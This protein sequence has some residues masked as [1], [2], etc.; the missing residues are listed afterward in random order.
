MLPTMRLASAAALLAALLPSTSFAQLHSDCNPLKGDKCPPNPAFGT[1]HEFN[2]NQS[3]PAGMFTNEAGMPVFNADTGGAFTISKQGQS[4]TYKTN[5]YFFWGRTEVIMKAAAGQ[6]IVSS[7]VLMSDVLDEIDWEFLGSKPNWVLTN[8]FGKGE[9]HWTNGGNS[10][11]P[12]SLQTQWHNFTNVWTKDKLEWWLD[13]D[14]VR[15]LTPKQANNTRNY[16]QTPM[17]LSLGIWSGG[18]P[19]LNPPGT[20]EWAGGET[21]FTKAPFTMYVKSAKVEDYSAGKE[22]SYGDSSG[23]WQSIKVTEG[24]STAYENLNRVPEKTT[25]EKWNELPSTT[26]TGVYAAAGGVVGLGLLVA[27]WFCFKKR[28]QG[29]Q[30]AALAMA[31]DE[32]ERV[33][34]ERWR[35]EGKNPDQLAFDGADATTAAKGSSVAAMYS[36]PRGV[37]SPPASAHGPATG[38]WDATGGGGG[39]APAGYA[40][41]GMLRQQSFGPASPGI[42][43][44]SPSQQSQNGTYSAVRSQSPGMA[45]DFPLPSS[46]S[47]APS[48]VGSP[49]AQGYGQ[50][51]RSMTASPGGQHNHGAAPPRSMTT[52]PGGYGGNAGAPAPYPYRG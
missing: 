10:T 38:A 23:S 25:A 32:Q 28:K 22:Y 45:P 48:R 52:S 39:V 2:F 50:P 34:L 8:F 7:I 24:N 6:G 44:G 41:G 12:T 9:P 30:E 19:K 37:D 42:A 31:K 36:V 16:P 27:L 51:P 40:P 14:L 43:P 47:Q 5:F 29:R 35:K 33:E 13:G 49:A 1:A 15:T 18:D 21:D 20:I 11:I 17:R 46:P 3:Q 26:K 4:V